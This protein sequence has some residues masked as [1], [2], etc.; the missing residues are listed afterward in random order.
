VHLGSTARRRWLTAGLLVVGT[1][2]QQGPDPNVDRNQ[3]DTMPTVS[4]QIGEQQFEAWL[5]D[6]T[7]TREKGLMFVEADELAAKPDGTHRGML[8][9]FARDQYLAFWMHNTIIPLDIAY[10]RSDGEIVRTYTM[11]PLETRTYPS[12]EPAQFA[13][14]VSAG[15]FEEL[16]IGPGDHVE[17]P[18]SVLKTYH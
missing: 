17:I 18:A 9:V 8:F 6:D 1:G 2:C 15:L 7:A 5:A 13:L 11:A 3:L 16:G 10:I 4:L 14:E 12:M